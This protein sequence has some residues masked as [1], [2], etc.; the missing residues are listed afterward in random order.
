MLTFLVGADGFFLLALSDLQLD[1][2]SFVSFVVLRLA[3]SYLVLLPAK[4]KI[5]DSN[6][7]SSSRLAPLVSKKIR[8]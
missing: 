6:S 1:F 3:R 8:I 7:N 4:K 5:V 2:D